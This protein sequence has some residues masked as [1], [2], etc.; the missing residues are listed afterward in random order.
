MLNTHSTVRIFDEDKE[1]LIDKTFDHIESYERILTMHEAGSEIDEVNINAGIQPVTVSEEVFNLVELALHHSQLSEGV[2]DITIGSLAS[3]WDFSSSSSYKPSQAEIDA[4][5]PLIGYEDVELNR[6]DLTIFLRE[7]G[8]KIDL[9][10]IAKGYIVDRAAQFLVENGV[11]AAVVDLGGD[12]FVIGHNVNGN[13]WNIGVQNP[14]LGRGQIVGMVKA[15]NQSIVTSGVYERN[16]EENGVEYHHLLSPFDG[17]PFMNDLA[18]VSI[19][20]ETSAEGD[21][22]STA[23]FGMGLER[24]LEFI[25]AYEGA[26]AIFIGYDKKVYITS[27]LEDKFKITNDNYELVINSSK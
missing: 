14:F 13:P 9:G 17:Y 20:S 24:G 25:E 21:A 16:F 23:A 3:I 6:E 5:L 1:H 4:V 18:G 15:V 12:I 22:L 8:M 7:K 11:E 10:G 27:G 19:V 2:F 26:E